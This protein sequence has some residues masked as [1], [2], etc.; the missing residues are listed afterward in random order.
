MTPEQFIPAVLAEIR[1]EL[2]RQGVNVTRLSAVTGISQPSLSRKLRG[3][4]PLGLLDTLLIC[5]ALHVT[6]PTLLGRA[7]DMAAA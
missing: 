5:D 1:A 4:S 3:E 7:S 6:V 2:G